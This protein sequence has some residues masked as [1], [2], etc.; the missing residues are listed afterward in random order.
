[1]TIG[2]H[3]EK[4][5]SHLLILRMCENFPLLTSPIHSVRPK[6]GNR[7]DGC[8]RIRLKGTLCLLKRKMN[9]SSWKNY[10]KNLTAPKYFIGLIQDQHTGKWKWLNGKSVDASQGKTPV[11][12]R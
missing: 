10:I 5:P 8:V 9:G 7:A 11:G 6:I 4:I 3:T 1:M 12:S 2:F